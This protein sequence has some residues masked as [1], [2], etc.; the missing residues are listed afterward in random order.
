MLEYPGLIRHEILLVATNLT[1]STG[2]PATALVILP[3]TFQKPT[4]H[5]YSF[6]KLTTPSR[7]LL[8]G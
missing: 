7:L 6:P 1:E 2:L 5:H 8:S 3:T 4:N